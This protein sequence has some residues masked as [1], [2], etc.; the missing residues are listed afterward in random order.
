[1]TNSE[2]M[3]NEPGVAAMTD[4]ANAMGGYGGMACVDAVVPSGGITI[5]VD[6]GDVACTIDNSVI[7]GDPLP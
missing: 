4:N 5:A 6:L 1:M 3:T 2:E 7:G